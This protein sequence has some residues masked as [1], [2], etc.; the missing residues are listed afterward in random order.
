MEENTEDGKDVE[1]K[2]NSE[3]KNVVEAAKVLKGLYKTD[4]ITT[5]IKQGIMEL[6]RVVTRL[7]YANKNR[8]K[9]MK[10]EREQ[11][12]KQ[13]SQTC[14]KCTERAEREKGIDSTTQTIED[15]ELEEEMLIEE[16]KRCQKLET[17]GK[18]MDITWPERAFE[19]TRLENGKIHKT[20]QER[21]VV[22]LTEDDM[23]REYNK[24][25]IDY[26][27]GYEALKI[28]E[29]TPGKETNINK[30]RKI[31]ETIFRGTNIEC[32][33]CSKSM[34]KKKDTPRS[35]T[36]TY[37][38]EE[39]I[40][41]KGGGNS[42][43]DTLRTLQTN[44]HLDKDNFRVKGVRSTRKDDLLVTV[45][46]NNK[47]AE[48][49]KATVNKRVG[50][51]RA[52]TIGRAGPK[53]VLHIKDLDKNTTEEDVKEAIIKELPETYREEITIKALRPAYGDRQ[54]VTVIITEEKATKLLNRGRIAI[55]WSECR[56]IE[57]EEIVRC[58]RC[59]GYNHRAKDCK[60]QD[61]SGACRK[62]TIKGHNA[63]NC[64]GLTRCALCETDGHTTGSTRCPEYRRAFKENR[65]KRIE[66][67]KTD[68]TKQCKLAQDLMTRVTDEEE[69]DAVIIS[70]PYKNMDNWFKDKAGMAVIWITD[71]GGNKTKSIK[72]IERGDG[73]VA[74]EMDKTVFLSCYISPNIKLDEFTEKL[75]GI[76]KTITGNRKKKV[77]IAGDLNSK[78]TDWGSARTDQRGLRVLDLCAKLNLI[79]VKNTGLNHT[80]ERNG[81]TSMIDIVILDSKTYKTLQSSTILDS[82]TGSDH[83]YLVHK[84]NNNNDN[85]NINGNRYNNNDKNNKGTINY[86]KFL[87]NYDSKINSNINTEWTS[88]RID[89]F[90]ET[91]ENA[92]NE[93]RRTLP[94]TLQNKQKAHWWKPE[95]QT[96]RSDCHHARRR[97]QRARKKKRNDSIIESLRKEYKARKDTLKREIKM[98]KIES[99]KRLQD[100]VEDDPWGRPYKAVFTTLKPR[101]PPNKLN[102]ED[103][104]KIIE[105]LF[106]TKPQVARDNKRNLNLERRRI[107]VLL[108]IRARNAK[109]NKDRKITT[110]EIRTIARSLSEKKAPGIDGVPSK[111]AKI[112]A[113]QRPGMLSDMYNAYYDLGYFPERWKTGKLVLIPKKGEARGSPADWRPLNMISN[114][115]KI[116]ER[117]MKDRILEETCF[118]ENQFGFRKGK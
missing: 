37:R 49:F 75:E 52:T 20:G 36:R 38:E 81:S 82:Y 105:G 84:F 68:A 63:D 78:S 79:T 72:L 29:A 90:I 86:S 114:L 64:K 69:I 95:L 53:K 50:G 93:S 100:M 25:I 101:T 6:V 13:K 88:N 97:M 108:G 103:M 5:E 94:V 11:M 44:M 46:G 109:E 48:R 65:Q 23:D 73:Y 41:I 57:R 104:E 7:Q 99:W 83:K 42:Y 115:A 55:G 92:I 54:N 47:E 76:E 62:C 56:V 12:E 96:L 98:A 26:F 16:I 60:G 9:K 106:V 27:Q 58:F 91:I 118:E 34:G 67:R 102:K 35:R 14:P 70:E 2:T 113:E 74:V 22:I 39:T 116:M 45:K 77:I 15:K 33:L 59:W 117:T 66:E 32:R 3:I 40:I 19:R 1:E 8:I 107:D 43:A 17:I 110:E 111:I 10:E 24:E 61:M 112:L 28:Q 31:A 71:K 30:T 18:V 80:F 89:K 51:V 4:N 87:Q 21:D 85:S